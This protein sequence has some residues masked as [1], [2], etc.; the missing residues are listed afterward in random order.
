MSNLGRGDLSFRLAI[1]VILMVT[2]AAVAF[3]GVWAPSVGAAINMAKVT[4]GGTIL[5]VDL[6]QKA[7]FGFNAKQKL[8]SGAVNGQLQ[9]Q[10]SAAALDV[11]SIALSV[12]TINGNTATFSG[13]A[14]VNGSGSFDFTVTVQD[15]GKPGK[16]NDTFGISLSNG[17]S[18]S[19]TLTGGNIKIHK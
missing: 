11:H 16:G 5:S 17:Y 4:G 19:G 13:T 1:G 8:P 2:V 3:V 9:Y 7:N 15:N 6:N 10:D 18:N 14:T 12:L